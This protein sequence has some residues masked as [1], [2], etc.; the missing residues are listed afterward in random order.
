MRLLSVLMVTDTSSVCVTN[1]L[2][3][4]DEFNRAEYFKD[5]RQDST[6]HPT[7]SRVFSH[8][9]TAEQPNDIRNYTT[10]R[11]DVQH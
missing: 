1:I 4:F 7:R 11:D 10:L 8:L 9:Y 6:D 5:Q 3:R 2:S